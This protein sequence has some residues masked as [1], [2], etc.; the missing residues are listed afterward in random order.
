MKITEDR[1][2]F[3][4]ITS[5]E[6]REAG[7][8]QTLHIPCQLAKFSRPEGRGAAPKV[9]RNVRKLSEIIENHQNS[10]NNYRRQRAPSSGAG[11]PETVKLHENHRESQ[12]LDPNHLE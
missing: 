9:T 3:T 10:R 6:G 5:N 1:R 11:S 7:P 12:K 4:R 8:A 2:N